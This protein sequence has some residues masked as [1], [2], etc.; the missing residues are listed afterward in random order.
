VKIKGFQPGPN[1]ETIVL[2]RGDGSQ[3]IFK[4]RA[5][6]D[7]SGFEKLCPSPQM[8]RS[9]RA[10]GD[11]FDNP[12]DDDYK[13]KS[14][15]RSSLE[16]DW[17]IIESLKATDGIQWEQVDYEKPSSW[18]LWRD[19]LKAAGFSKV[20]VGRIFNGVWAANSLDERL[21]KQARDSFFRSQQAA[22]AQ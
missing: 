4:A 13:K 20:E 17:M 11:W 16:I 15:D 10:G 3:I 18:K 22:K 1:I 9:Q 14:D 6:L 8:P 12:D 5:V 7:Y 19:E 2:P 21:V